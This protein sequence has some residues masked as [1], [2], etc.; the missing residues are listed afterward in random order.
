MTYPLLNDIQGPQD[1]KGMS[2]EVLRDLA[3]EMRQRII[4]VMATNGGH[5]ASGLGAVE[6]TIALH[7]VFNSPIDKFI[8]DVGHQTYPHK[9]LTGRH[10]QFNTVRKS[11]GLCGFTHPKESEH[12]HFFAGHVGT[13]LSQALG[14]AKNRDLTQR[15][16]YVI[17]IIGDGT[18]TCGMSLEALNNMSRSLKKFIVILNDNKM[19]I[20]KNVG[21]ISNI[22]S[23]ILSN[24][25]STKLYQEIDHL[26][27][28]IP[29][30][31]SKLSKQGHKITES[32]KNLVSP[33]AFFES[34]GLSYIGPVNGHDIKKLLDIFEGV[35][36][37]NWPV[38]VHCL[39]N[40]GQGLDVAL[41]NPVAWHGVKPFDISTG[42]FIPS[43]VRGKTFPAIFGEHIVT[44]AERDPSLVVVTPAMATG[45]CLETMMQRFPER[46]I[47]VGIAE[48]H[49]IT[50]SGSL[51]FGKKMKVIASI[52][53]TFLQRA[54]DNVFHDICLQG[55]PVVFAIDR[56][57]VAAGDGATH[58]G[59]YDIAWLNAMPNMIIS[60]PR[61]GHLLKE[62][63]ESAHHWE[64]PAAIRYPNL[65]TEDSD[66]P[67]TTRHVGCGEVLAE[68]E[69]I[70]IIGL[71]VTCDIALAVRELLA[72][73]GL[74]AT[75]MDPIFVKPLDSEL[76]H[77]LL[78]THNKV[79]TIEEHSVS[80]GLGAIINNFLMTNGYTNIQVL[81]CGIPEAFVEHG[82]R[83]T[84]LEEL[85]LSPEKILHRINHHFSLQRL[86]VAPVT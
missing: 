84:L 31:G 17:A 58:N 57:G 75:V 42:K 1:I 78:A 11:G 12:D 83:D 15:Q 79:I 73:R 70:L 7:K 55:F 45:S 61:N 28:K 13:A 56:A 26:L 53:S 35:K 69:E 74:T 46:C 82:S 65:A 48:S 67:L 9:L 14:V 54:L 66:A 81:N 5:L 38:I 43:K 30:Y 25:T 24:P 47:D 8:W 21:Q 68:G 22:L 80:T 16:E 40:K 23:R 18:L 71:G 60:Q 20:S 27:S 51:A 85:Q 36:D 76:L 2:I 86:T 34:F 29:G 59:I 62:L 39:T 32:I 52:Y 4:E 72:Q 63:L 44:M 37:S 33:A 64:R 10:Q 50:Y 77:R 41:K 3:K 6:F 49:A 19:C